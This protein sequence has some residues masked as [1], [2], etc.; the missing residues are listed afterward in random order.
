MKSFFIF[1]IFFLLLIFQLAFAPR[2]NIFGVSPNFLFAA[3]LILVIKKD[4]PSVLVWALAVGLALDLFSSEAFGVYSLSFVFV[5]WL[6]SVL[7]KNILKMTDL[8]GQATLIVLACTTFS[9]LNIF[10]I[11]FFY[12]VSSGS[13][14][15]FWF[16]LWRIVPLEVALNILFSFAMLLIYKKINGLLIR[17]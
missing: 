9:I 13:Q 14:V 1:L 10:L 17:I 15:Y 2:L 5:G 8:F 16:A 3:A 7:G 4:T 11:K 6:A 12:W